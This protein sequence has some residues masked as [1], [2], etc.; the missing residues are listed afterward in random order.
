MIDIHETL[1][2][3]HREMEACKDIQVEYSAHDDAPL[4]YA[5]LGNAI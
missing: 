3:V 5:N 4:Q 1:M 2:R